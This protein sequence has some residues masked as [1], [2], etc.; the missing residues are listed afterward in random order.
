M[1]WTNQKQEAWFTI[2]NDEILVLFNPDGNATYH[3]EFKSECPH[4]ISDTGYRSEFLFKSNIQNYNITT[5]KDFIKDF[6]SVVL[7]DKSKE[8]KSFQKGK[9]R[10]PEYLPQELF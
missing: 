9:H 1:D 4:C 10:I 8:L 3:I 7:R 2:N 5:F 6:S